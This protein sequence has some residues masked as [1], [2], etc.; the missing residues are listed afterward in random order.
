MHLIPRLKATNSVLVVVDVQ[1]KLLAAIPSAASLVKNVAFLLDA[2]KELHVPIRA[3]E[4][5]PK[6][7]GPT[8]AEIARRIGKDI[9][10][11]TKF[12]CCGADD[13][14]NELQTRDH[15]HVV[16]VGME[17]HVCI[18]QTAFDLIEA[19]IKVFVPVDAVASRHDIDCQT[20]LTRMKQVGAILTTVEAVAFEWLADASHPA[21]KAVQKLVIE[22]T[23]Q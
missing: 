17:T 13:F 18:S 15:P 12:S 20:A 16:L 3:T 22:R 19:G 1:D 21:F 14:L 8:T 7:L 23:K 10:A 11:K 2:A 6:G 4:Q 9:P 5:Y